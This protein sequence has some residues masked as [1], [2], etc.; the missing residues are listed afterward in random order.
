MEN[1][2]CSRLFCSDNRAVGKFIRNVLKTYKNVI[3]LDLYNYEDSE[4]AGG[5]GDKR[6]VQICLALKVTYVNVGFLIILLRFR[7]IFQGVRPGLICI[8]NQITT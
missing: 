4:W 5:G 1:A 3:S 2:I 8:G 6:T 7:Y